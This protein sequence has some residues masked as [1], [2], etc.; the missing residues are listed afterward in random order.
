M[1]LVTIGFAACDENGKVIVTE[2]VKSGDYVGHLSVTQ[3][4][5]SV[6]EKH[7][8]AVD[9]TVLDDK[10]HIALI[11]NNVKFAEKMP[12]LTFIKID[13]ISA[14]AIDNFKILAGTNIIPT[15]AGGPFPAYTVQDLIGKVSNDSLEITMNMGTF[16][17]TFKGAKRQTQK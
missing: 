12:E 7:D 11:F 13:S 15:Y 1:A 5:N 10:I 8:Q 16:P 14:A 17:V 2:E 3:E 4:D 9:F 6:Y